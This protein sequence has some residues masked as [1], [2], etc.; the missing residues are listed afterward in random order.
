MKPIRRNLIMP[1]RR[2]S[3]LRA[4][5]WL[6][7][8][9]L[10]VAGGLAAEA[11]ETASPAGFDFSAFKMISER[12]IFN[13]TR[14][15]GSK[16]RASDKTPPRVDTITLYGTFLYEKGLFAFFTGSSPEFKQV[17]D[18]GKTIAGYTIA[19]VEGG[20]VKL[21]AGTNTVELRVGMQLRR[22]EGGDWQ[23]ADIGATPASVGGGSIAAA[24]AASSG[25][26][27]DVVKRMMKQREEEL[28]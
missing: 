7:G 13:T 5:A 28:K 20:R 14:S 19:E 3:A 22:V 1:P 17:L 16:D 15:P 25:E 4:G 6:A 24:E 2:C 26:S 21:T 8:L 9:I 10:A 12:N 27:D 18:A 23:V 11:P